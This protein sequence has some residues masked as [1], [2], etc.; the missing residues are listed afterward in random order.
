MATPPTYV[1]KQVS[2][3]WVDSPGS[4][5]ATFSP[6]VGN[7]LASLTGAEGFADIRLAG[8]PTWSDLQDNTSASNVE[9]HLHSATAGGGSITPTYT[10][11]GAALHY[12]FC[13]AEFSGSDGFGASAKVTSGSGA[14][15]LSLTTTQ[16]NSAIVVFVGDWNA[17]NGSSRT[18]RTVNGFTPSAANGKELVYAGTAGSDY[19]VYAAYYP[20]A[21]TAGA[22]TVGLSAPTGQ[23]YSVVALEVKG[24][25]AG[26]PTTVPVSLAGAVASAGA[27]L[28]QIMRGIS[29][30][31][32]PAGAATR[33]TG[34]SLT[35]TTTSAGTLTNRTGK[36]PAGAVT[37]GGT[38]GRQVGRPLS[39][40]VAAAATLTRQT[41]R[42]LVGA[43]ASSGSV[44]TARVALLALSGGATSAGAL[45]RRLSR[46]TSGTGTS[47]GALARRLDRT[48]T[49]AV[50]SAGALTRLKAIVRG[51]TGSTNS[52]GALTRQTRRTRTASVAPTATVQRRLNRALFAT[53]TSAGILTAIKAVLRTFTGAVASAGALVRQLRRQ[54]QADAPA[55]G[56]VTFRLSRGFSGSTWSSGSLT[57]M[58]LVVR[59]FGGAVASAGSVRRLLARTLT[60]EADPVGTV[61]RLLAR[62]FGRT[63]QPTGAVTPQPVAPPTSVPPTLTLTAPTPSVV[64]LNRPTPGTPELTIPQPQVIVLRFP[65]ERL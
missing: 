17:I 36:A 55:A 24:V 1:G 8:G 32:T 3:S 27:L 29:G 44:A 25:A 26:G 56:R 52:A 57:A 64:E 43:V 53:V 4:K 50:A 11:N 7:R 23:K 39:G 48:T 9:Q 21:G 45:V 15:S 49:G 22:K 16:D 60:A 31:A 42:A 19:I 2:A 12:G 37:S 54:E 20:D 14:P 51:F 63:I 10:R 38:M 40:A 41:S 33:R 28:R 62:L 46:S 58:R 34:R 6:A 65:W 61:R 35:A 13:I 47:A 30:A 5:S 59:A 18:W